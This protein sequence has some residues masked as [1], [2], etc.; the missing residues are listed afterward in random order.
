[1]YNASM[2]DEQSAT[3]GKQGQLSTAVQVLLSPQAYKEVMELARASLPGEMFGA[4]IGSRLP[5][6]G[7]RADRQSAYY[8]EIDEVVPVH[9]VPAGLHKAPDREE[10]QEL[11][12]R[13]HEAAP[14]GVVSHVN[15][16]PLTTNGLDEYPSTDARCILG[17]FYADPGIAI[18]PPRFDIVQAR[19]LPGAGGLLLLLNPVA[20]QGA[21]YVWHGEQ[22]VHL[23]GGFKATPTS[24]GGSLVPWDGQVAGASRWLQAVGV[25]YAPNT[26]G[27]GQ[28]EPKQPA[29]VQWEDSSSQIAESLLTGAKTQEQASLLPPEEV[30]ECLDASGPVESS[31]LPAALP[32]ALVNEQ[33]VEPGTHGLDATSSVELD[34]S[35]EEIVI[36]ERAADL[37]PVGYSY[38]S[39][40]AETAEA[41]K[42][43]IGQAQPLDTMVSAESLSG[44]ADSA[45]LD[46]PQAAPAEIAA[47]SSLYSVDAARRGSMSH[48]RVPMLLVGGLVGLVVVVGLGTTLLLGEQSSSPAPAPP[49]YPI[50]KEQG[51]SASASSTPA[52]PPSSVPAVAIV[53]PSPTAVAA[54]LATETAGSNATPSFTA[55]ATPYSSPLATVPNI[56][57]NDG[58]SPT[59]EPL[60]PTPVTILPLAAATAAATSLDSDTSASA[61]PAIT[62]PTTVPTRLTTEAS[63]RTYTV[64]RGDTLS[65]IAQRYGITT[66]ELMRVNNKSTTVI[67]PGQV[68]LLPAGAINPHEIPTATASST[69]TSIASMA[70]YTSTP[71]PSFAP[72]TETPTL[73]SPTITT[74]APLETPFPTPAPTSIG[75]E[76]PL[77]EP[78]ASPEA[79]ILPAYT[80]T[81]TASPGAELTPTPTQTLGAQLSPTDTPAPE[82]TEEQPEPTPTVTYELSTPEPMQSP[83]SAPLPTG[84]P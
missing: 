66:A 8:V 16:E 71:S 63:G 22:L 40:D 36:D 60:T 53:P 18:F 55:T 12:S 29:E 64:Q 52:V 34:D 45:R 82:P 31:M 11:V 79:T 62:R 30:I 28:E 13:L 32:A 15:K 38:S 5:P 43:S 51:N 39:A 35:P 75:V 2:F 21:F 19:Q 73:V 70:T 7:G 59:S 4:L 27:Y 80:E 23:G 46:Q 72:P 49:D 67:V 48:R 42:T 1:M 77:P 14:S 47:K 9:L 61:T 84:R 20:D 68:L 24:N 41:K 26:P 44:E 65:E 6:E 69:A 25:G 74:A 17:C 83:I 76:S 54:P 50:T 58:S 37:P 3:A 33:S 57:T 78:T 56:G 10:W 81:P